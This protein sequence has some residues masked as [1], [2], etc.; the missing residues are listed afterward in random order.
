M[1]YTV[2]TNADVTEVDFYEPSADV[3][4]VDFYEPYLFTEGQANFYEPYLFTKDQ[5]PK[6][7]HVCVCVP[8]LVL[9]TSSFV[10]ALSR[11]VGAR[12]QRRGHLIL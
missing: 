1:V 3:T 9:E 2:V 8:Q 6:R 11:S 10:K 7:L 5:V 4:E 12:A